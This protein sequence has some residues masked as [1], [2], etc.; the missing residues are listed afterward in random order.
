LV[1]DKG[2]GT[3]SLP[4]NLTYSLDPYDENNLNKGI[5][6]VLNTPVEGKG[7]SDSNSLK[8]KVSETRM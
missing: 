6:K 4:R 1:R 2:S 3:M 5:E 7:K 8:T